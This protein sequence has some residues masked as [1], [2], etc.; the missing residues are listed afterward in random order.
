[1]EITMLTVNA[2]ANQHAF[3][4]SR[5]RPDAAASPF[6]LDQGAVHRTA[7]QHKPGYHFLA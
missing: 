1:M 5:N 2:S 4:I 7:D 6:Q 3:S